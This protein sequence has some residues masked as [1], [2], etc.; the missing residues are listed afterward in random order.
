MTPLGSQDPDGG[1]IQRVEALLSSLTAVVSARVIL[2][3]KSGT[4]VHILATAE[5]PVSEVS[6]AVTSALTW[7]LGFEVAPDQITVVQSRLSRAELK[8]LLGPESAHP[9][10]AAPGP[11]APETP[12]PRQPDP[13]PL[14]HNRRLMDFGLGGVG[15]GDEARTSIGDSTP[16][17]SGPPVEQEPGRRVRHPRT[18][19]RQRPFDR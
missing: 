2:D 6:R 10:L 16:R 12:A 8:A 1:L 18:V 19:D 11:V 13:E 3:Q 7:G 17:T 4:H 9:P 14:I 5:M 15:G